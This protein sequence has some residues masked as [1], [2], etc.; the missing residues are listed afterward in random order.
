MTAPEAS[1]RVADIQRRAAEDPE[2]A[3]KAFDTYPWQADL[4][5]NRKLTAALYAVEP[6]A[7]Q[8]AEI[9][10][11]TRIE[12]F[13]ERIKVQIEKDAYKQWLSKSGNLQPRIFSNQTLAQEAEGNVPP[14]QR[15][16]AILHAELGY[17]PY[18]EAVDPSVPSWQRQAPKTELFVPRTALPSDPSGEAT[19]YPK[20]FEEIVKFLQTGQAVPGIREIPDTVI[21]DPSISTHGA[22]QAPLKPWERKNAAAAPNTE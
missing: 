3:F 1:Q 13:A 22:M 6:E 7:S 9:A 5:F 2:V 19:P 10:L 15:R 17:P 4:L 11:Q 20:K 16:L 21:E 14:E 8:L 12:R 18:P